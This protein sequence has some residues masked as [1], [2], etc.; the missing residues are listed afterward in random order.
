L[1]GEIVDL[2]RS[3][4]LHDADQVGRVGHVAVVQMKGNAGLVRIVHEMVD[5]RGVERRRTALDAVHQI[6]LGEKE[7][8]EIGAILPGSA[9]DQG[10]PG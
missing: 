3:R 9:R 4:L 6:A 8:G 2:V 1:R 10:D 7:L 5:A